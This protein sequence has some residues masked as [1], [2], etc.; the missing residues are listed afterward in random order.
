MKFKVFNI[1]KKASLPYMNGW[2]AIASLALIKT[3]LMENKEQ[4]KKQLE[5]LDNNKTEPEKAEDF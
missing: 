2:Y 5:L 3:D 4:L 1:K